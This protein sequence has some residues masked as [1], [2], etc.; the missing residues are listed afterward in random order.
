M[1]DPARTAV[2]GRYCVMNRLEK[3]TTFVVLTGINKPEVRAS[4]PF[5]GRSLSYS[6]TVEAVRP[7]NF[8]LPGYPQLSTGSLDARYDRWRRTG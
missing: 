8:Y 3:V 4:I 6:E 2:R 5:A 1:R 7:K